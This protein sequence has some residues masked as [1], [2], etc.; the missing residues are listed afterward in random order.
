MKMNWKVAE[1]F[2]ARCKLFDDTH[3]MI[4]KDKWITDSPT[5]VERENIKSKIVETNFFMI[6][7][8]FA[9]TE[10]SHVNTNARESKGSGYTTGQ[11]L[12]YTEIATLQKSEKLKTVEREK[13]RLQPL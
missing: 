4:K 7:L 13:D 6:V 8:M 9:F 5:N 10:M 12:Q 2:V 11:K 1:E 3:S